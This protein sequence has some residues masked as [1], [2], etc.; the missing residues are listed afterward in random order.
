MWDEAARHPYLV[1]LL[2]AGVAFYPF[3]RAF[4]SRLL[5]IERLVEDPPYR[6]TPAD[7][8]DPQDEIERLEVENNELRGQIAELEKEEAGDGPYRTPGVTYE[9]DCPCSGQCG[10]GFGLGTDVPRSPSFARS[11]IRREMERASGTF[12]SVNRTDLQFLLK[13]PSC[14]RGDCDR[15][16][17]ERLEHE[18]PGLEF[19]QS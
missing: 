10:G 6:L 14:D 15:C 4:W 19:R 2:I 5:R 17:K 18:N 9:C 7:G 16:V 8:W 13:C 1:G 3:V 12:V 11:E